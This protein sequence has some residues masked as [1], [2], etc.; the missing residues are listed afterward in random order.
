[1]YLA[2]IGLFTRGVRRGRRRN[3]FLPVSKGSRGR[4]GVNPPSLPRF[5]LYLPSI[6]ACCDWQL[7]RL[8]TVFWLQFLAACHPIRQLSP[9]GGTNP[10]GHYEA[11]LIPT[12]VL[13][14]ASQVGFW[15]TIPCLSHASVGF[16]Q[17]LQCTVVTA[18]H[19][20]RLVLSEGLGDSCCDVYF[21]FLLQISSLV[22]IHHMLRV[23]FTHALS[24]SWNWALFVNAW[25]NE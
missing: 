6:D 8:K 16:G 13:A 25:R 2:F 4:W 1:M 11:G 17:R 10:T 24:L 18:L 9:G 21:F 12:T 3:T 5:P 20:L 23:I 14:E 7:Y 22:D 15:S 19:H